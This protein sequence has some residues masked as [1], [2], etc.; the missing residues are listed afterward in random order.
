[1]RSKICLIAS[2][3]AI[4][5]AAWAD[6]PTLDEVRQAVDALHADPAPKTAALDRSK[7][8]KRLAAPLAY[9]FIWHCDEG[10]AKRSRRQGAVSAGKLEEFASCLKTSDWDLALESKSPTVPTAEW[11]EADPKKLPKPLATHRA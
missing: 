9:R 1:M 8:A 4:G 3:V 10:C 2:I 5:R 11:F 7:I 6:K